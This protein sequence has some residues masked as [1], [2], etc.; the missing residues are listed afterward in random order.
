MR[1]VLL[2]ISTIAF[3]TI[4]CNHSALFAQDS[5]AINSALGVWLTA[6]GTSKIEIYREGEEF[7][8][9][10]VWLKRPVYTDGSDG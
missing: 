2:L 8:G 1:K 5:T 10:I 9:K 7:C 6:G 4:V 3:L